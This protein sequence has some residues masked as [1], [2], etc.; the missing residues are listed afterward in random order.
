MNKFT[1]GLIAGSLIGFAGL[2]YAMN[3]KKTRKRM[4]SDG[5]KMA[6]KAGS[7]FENI[8]DMF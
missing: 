5:K 4:M 2:S 3:D 6:G 8:T 1:T 7:L